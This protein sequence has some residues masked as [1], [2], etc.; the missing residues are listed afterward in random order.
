MTS[1]AGSRPIVQVAVGVLVRADG[2]V[3][4][5]DRPAG[6][7]YAG[8]WEF[9]GGK[10]EAG[11]TVE[12]ALARELHEELGIDIGA[13]VPWVVFEHDYPHAYVR[14]H[15]R[16]VFDWRGAPHPHEGQRFD[17]FLPADAPQPLLPA[18]VPA[19]RWLQLPPMYAVSN[20]AALGGD[21][22][23]RRLDRALERGLRLLLVREPGIDAAQL[24]GLAP[25]LLAR[26][27]AQGARVL[28]SSRHGRSL[29]PM[30]D[31]V[32]LTARD[33]MQA[34]QRPSAGLTAAS[35]HSR[36][37]LAHAHR[38]GCD[39]AMAGPVRTTPSHPGAQPLGWGGFEAIAQQTPLP[40]YAIGGLNAGDLAAAM[41]S[42][43]HGVASLRAAWNG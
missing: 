5:A 31:G 13:S 6:K 27:R 23:V 7:P 1:P 25:A 26:A 17:F 40:L 36:G 18:A 20:I 12:A 35:V 42:G 15:F 2:A 43:A 28:I 32:H 24:A 16:R 34:T 22:F 11:E 39:F 19:L 14:L 3:L 9:P 4:L 38:L 29:W 33:L 30:F 10:I 37:E 41:R 21:A 8:Y